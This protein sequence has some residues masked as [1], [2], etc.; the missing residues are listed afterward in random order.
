MTTPNQINKCVKL[1]FDRRVYSMFEWVPDMFMMQVGYNAHG[2]GHPRSSPLEFTPI[3]L[4]CIQQ[5]KKRKEK[6]NKRALCLTKRNPGYPK[7]RTCCG[8]NVGWNER[9]LPLTTCICQAGHGAGWRWDRSYSPED[10]DLNGLPLLSLKPP[11]LPPRINTVIQNQ[12]VF[13]SSSCKQSEKP[14]FYKLYLKRKE[15]R[16][17]DPGVSW[18]GVNWAK[19]VDT[20]S[21]IVRHTRGD[22][23]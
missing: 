18:S 19:K 6:H 16:S 8:Q 1:T 11:S 3:C 12:H 23:W 15:C 14:P 4:V 2:D 13:F 17:D 5:G 21:Q 7:G 9:G 20:Y 22:L 10:W